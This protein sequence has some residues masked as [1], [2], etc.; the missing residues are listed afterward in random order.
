[1]KENLHQFVDKMIQSDFTVTETLELV[2]KVYIEKVL[3]YHKQNVSA[4]AKT[5]QIHRNTLMRKIKSLGI[6]E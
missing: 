6:R 3:N 1:M 2:E 4:A 5:M